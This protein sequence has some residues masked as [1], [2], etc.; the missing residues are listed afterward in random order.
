MTNKEFSDSFDSLVDSYRRFKDFD[1]K[2]ELDSIEFNEYEKSLFLSMAQEELV[3]NIYSGRNIYGESFESTE[4][5]RRYLDNLVFT[6]KP[7]V[8][9]PAASGVS[10]TSKFYAL[11][12]S[13]AFII[14]EQATL[15][16]ES[17]GCA[18][19]SVV[20]VVPVTHDEYNR[21]RKNPFR[22]V[23]GNRILRLDAGTSKVELVSKYTFND[24]LIRY[25][26]KPS[27]IV[28]E[29]L[30]DLGLSIDGY[31]T[32]QGCS[33][34]PILHQTILKRAVQLALASKGITL[35]NQQ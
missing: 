9:T 26:A 29:D 24:Y 6:S 34:N 14:Y 7:T 31:D 33:L 32:V 11:P 16:D 2:E 21:I 22:G 5:M 27:P 20:N 30:T 4:E 23:T 13:V 17:A 28:L 19:G 8:T 1:K 3:V 25:V 15:N 18:N 12:E 35:N 10:D